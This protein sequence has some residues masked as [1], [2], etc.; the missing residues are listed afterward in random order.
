MTDVAPDGKAEAA[1]DD[2]RH[3]GEIYDRV[4]HIAA[5]ASACVNVA[6]HIEARVAERGDRMEHAVP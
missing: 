4:C 6:Q 1:D 3:D 5:E 2:E